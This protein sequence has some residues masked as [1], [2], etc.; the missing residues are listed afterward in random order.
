MFLITYLEK[1]KRD[2][3]K[4]WDWWGE[5]EWEGLKGIRGVR[6]KEVRWKGR[7]VREGKKSKSER[8]RRSKRESKGERERN[9]DC[10][11]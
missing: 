3:K 1:T 9:S 2:D 6:V 8:E 7:S 11:E 4:R 10:H 5:C